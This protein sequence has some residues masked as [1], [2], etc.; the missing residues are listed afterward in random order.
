[1]VFRG[2]ESVRGKIY[3]T[4]RMLEHIDMFNYLAYNRLV[5]CEE[6]VE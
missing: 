3:L 2:S 1:M 5:S 4:D 6:E